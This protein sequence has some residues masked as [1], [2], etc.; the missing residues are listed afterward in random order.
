MNFELMKKQ[1]KELGMTQQDLANKCGLSKTTIFNYESG[2]FEP[3]KENIETLARVLNLSENDLLLEDKINFDFSEE[4]Y[5][6]TFDFLSSAFTKKI[7]DSLEK[8]FKHSN[9][10]FKDIALNLTNLLNSLTSKQYIFS[11]TLKKIVAF[12]PSSDNHKTFEVSELEQYV[13]NI[14]S[15]TENLEK[16]NRSSIDNDMFDRLLNADSNLINTRESALKVTSAFIPI[17]NMTLDTLTEYN[18]CNREIAQVE[19]EYLKEMYIKTKESLTTDFNIDL[20]KFNDNLSK[21]SKD[22]LIKKLDLEYKKFEKKYFNQKNNKEGDP[23][24]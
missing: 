6:E 5:K 7:S 8:R 19:K 18:S 1:R 20:S 13:L 12:D 16:T 11:Y 15:L 23:D 3:T 2:K 22:E 17:V 4:K 21:K 10:D 14:L 9:L 24:E